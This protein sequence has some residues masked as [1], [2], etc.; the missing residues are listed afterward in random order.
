MKEIK[1]FDIND[2]VRSVSV[3]TLA[4]LSKSED[5]KGLVCKLTDGTVGTI[6][7]VVEGKRNPDID[8]LLDYVRNKNKA[9]EET[10]VVE[11]KK[12]PE[13][14]LENPEQTDKFQSN[15]IWIGTDQT[16]G[17]RVR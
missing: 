16:E 5:G 13:K 15:R 8:V 2:E 12:V 4:G 3:E 17:E 9:K 7:F 14:E 11:E 10:P 6:P 1:I